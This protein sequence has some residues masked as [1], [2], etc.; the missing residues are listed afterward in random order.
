LGQRADPRH[1]RGGPGTRKVLA[2]QSR[3][4]L[5][6]AVQTNSGPAL[7]LLPPP[8]CALRIHADHGPAQRGAQLAQRLLAGRRQNP[9]FDRLRRIVVEQAGGLGDQ[10]GAGKVDCSGAEGVQ[11]VRQPP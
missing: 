11:R 8:L 5:L 10:P 6:V 3:R 1:G 9:V 4:A 2:R 7:G